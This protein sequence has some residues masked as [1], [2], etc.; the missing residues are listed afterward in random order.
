MEMSALIDLF[1]LFLRIR[2]IPL[3]MRA[4]FSHTEKEAN[5][6]PD[7][8][9]RLGWTIIDAFM[10]DG[11]LS[12]SPLSEKKATTRIIFARLSSPPNIGRS[13]E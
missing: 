11:T 4:C 2:N 12:H 10:K 3:L 9:R 5:E 6:L 7:E 13:G 8:P 1:F